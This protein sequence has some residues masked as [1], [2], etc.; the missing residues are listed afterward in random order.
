MAKKKVNSRQ[1]GKRGERNA[2]NYLKGI[3]FPDAKRGQQRSGAEIADVLCEETLPNVHLEVKYGMD[4]K[5]FDMCLDR[6]EKA[7][8]QAMRDAGDKEWAVLW[9]PKGYRH[10][11]LSFIGIP[12]RC[13]VTGDDRIRSSLLW[14]Q[15]GGL[16]RQ[17]SAN[18]T[19]P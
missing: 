11:R 10:W 7:I 15:N 2:V 14:L 3:G 16:R 9:K 8:G 18:E 4:L 17:G 6:H 1:K 13:T 19:Q 12:V 5:I